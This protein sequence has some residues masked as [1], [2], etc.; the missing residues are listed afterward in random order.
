MS[1]TEAPA[2]ELRHVRKQFG[3]VVAVDDLS[4]SVDEGEFISLLGPS[5]CGK[6]TSLRVLAGFETPDRGSVL[7]RGVDVTRVPPNRRN[8]NLVFQQYELFP[9]MTVFENVA[10]G[11]RLRRTPKA[12]ILERVGRMLEIVGVADLAARSARHLSGGQQQRVALARA[13]VNQPAV[14]LLDEPL[15]ALDAKLR[16]SMQLELKK[17]QRELRTTF[18]YVTHDQEE[19]LLLS[20][21]VAVMHNGQLLQFDRPGKVYANP[22]TPFV[23][24]FVGLL[25]VIDIDE[26]DVGSSDGRSGLDASTVDHKTTRVGVRPE[27][28]QIERSSGARTRTGENMSRFG[29]V[30]QVNYLGSVTDL[31]VELDSHVRIVARRLSD[32]ES[33]LLGQGTDVEVS[34]PIDAT[35][36]LQ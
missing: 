31:V 34:W 33:A 11:L 32:D 16:R 5:G 2:L 13:L 35:I 19:A 27:R 3:E 22:A 9:H 10:Y 18:V 28:I 7:L 30:I 26:R 14:L 20:D 6:T 17:I 12:E 29:K 21:R 8:V 15:A 23:A 36:G 1:M 24:D 4:F 25:N